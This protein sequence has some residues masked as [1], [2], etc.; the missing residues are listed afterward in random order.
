MTVLTAPVRE[1]D[2]TMADAD[3]CMTR[4]TRAIADLCLGKVVV[5][6]GGDADTDGYLVVAGQTA[7]GTGLDFI[8]RHSSGFLC[9]PVSEDICGRIALPAMVGADHDAPGV[10]YTVA[11]DAAEGV[12]TGIS[13]LD[14]AVTLRRLADPA[15]TPE[16]FT[17]PGHVVPIRA[18]AA[19]V[20][21]RPYYAEATVDLMRAAGLQHVGGAA[22]LV[23]PTDPTSIADLVESRAF[24]DAHSLNWVSIDDVAAYRSRTEVH[25]RQTFRTV[26]TS[27]HGPVEAVGY[28]SDVTDADYVVYS[29]SAPSPSSRLRAH[30]FFEKDFAPHAPVS[31]PIADTA[32]TEAM[33]EPNRLV[34]VARLKH[35]HGSADGCAGPN[36]SQYSSRIAD[37]AQVLRQFGIEESQLVDPLPELSDMLRA[38]THSVPIN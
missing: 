29:P 1:E 36:S 26:R 34:V 37:I 18:H 11:V 31:S 24:A 15:S 5:L 25:I 3:N 33:A 16:S 7:T 8:V 13:A 35:D 10:D 22:A 21:T 6:V 19:G 4:V 27:P 38:M 17:R 14:R 12:G 2:P 30:A 20:L 28:H 23:S 32:I 9:A